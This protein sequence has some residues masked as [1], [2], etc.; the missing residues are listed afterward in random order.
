VVVQICGCVVS[1]LGS[2]H[3]AHVLFRG[4][5]PELL[6]LDH[7]GDVLATDFRCHNTTLT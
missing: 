5:N 1:I 2:L 6:F 7:K 3:G 4:V